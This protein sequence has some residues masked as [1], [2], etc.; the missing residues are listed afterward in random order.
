MDVQ[1]PPETNKSR[2]YCTNIVDLCHVYVRVDRRGG[3]AFEQNREETTMK[4]TLIALSAV[5]A[6]AVASPALAAKKH[7][8][9]GALPEDPR[10]AM[11]KKSQTWCS[12]QSSCNGWDKYF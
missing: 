3:P 9:G 7:H 12:L 6:V 8:G 4:A 11:A 2:F 5:V 10:I 1:L